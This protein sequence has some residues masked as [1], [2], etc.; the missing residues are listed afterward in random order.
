MA[1]VRKSTDWKALELALND[2][3][4]D[5]GEFAELAVKAVERTW[6]APEGIDRSSSAFTAQEVAVLHRGGFDLSPRGPSDPD[7]AARTAASLVL[8]EARAATVEEVAA[9]LNVSRARIRQRALER[10]LYALREGDEWR[11]PRWQFDDHGRPI[12]GI[13]R[14]VSELPRGV[15]PVAV[16]R[17]LSEPIPDLEISDQAVSPLQWLRGGGDP[18]PV[19]AIAREL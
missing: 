10:S 5:P 14:V 11:F 7:I 15:H 13:A 8:M 2:A 18:E 12:P 19:A 1:Q 6:H 17:F 3:G 9:A 4:I 16:W